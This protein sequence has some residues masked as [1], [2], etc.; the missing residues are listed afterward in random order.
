MPGLDSL[1]WHDVENGMR[2]LAI[3]M[4]LMLAATLAIGLRLMPQSTRRVARNIILFLVCFGLVVVS[5][6][7]VSALERG[8]AVFAAPDTGESVDAIVVLGRG[9]RLNPSRVATVA[10]LWNAGR[11]PKV[12]ASGASDAP[13][14]VESLREAGIPVEALG[15]EECSRTT[16]ENAWFSRAVLFPQGVRRILLVTDW[17]HLWRSQMTYESVGFSVITHPSPLRD[18]L[19]RKRRL[20]LMTRESL[21]LIAYGLQ[22]RL[23]DRTTLDT[24]AY[25]EKRLSKQQCLVGGTM[26]Q[27]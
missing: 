17:P 20:S 2:Q 15:G 27:A 3:P 13:L 12:F 11:S 7:G 1:T 14:I 5:P 19:S 22:G 25:V 6:T 21:G 10:E 16:E 9:R 23:G 8:M 4:A 24:P 26:E 18:T